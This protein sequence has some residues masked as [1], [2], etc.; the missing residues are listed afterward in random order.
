MQNLNK[1]IVEKLKLNKDTK[2]DYKPTMDGILEVIDNFLK[3][4]LELNKKYYYVNRLSDNHRQIQFSTGAYKN[5][6]KT[7]YIAKSIEDLLQELSIKYNIKI[8]YYNT[9][10]II[11]IFITDKLIDDTYDETY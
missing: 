7:D 9:S 3:K 2:L 5:K 8:H 1:Y 11:N 10:S 6:E 4:E